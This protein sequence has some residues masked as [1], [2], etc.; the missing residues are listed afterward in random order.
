MKSISIAPKPNKILDTILPYEANAEFC[1]IF[2]S[3]FG[4]WS[5]KKIVF[6]DLLTF[7]LYV[8]SAIYLSSDNLRTR[9]SVLNFPKMHQNY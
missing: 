7:T 8:G 6:V 3:F 1:Q 4:Q 5:Y 9:M 2:R